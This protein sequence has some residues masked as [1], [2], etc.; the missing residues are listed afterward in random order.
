MKMLYRTSFKT[1]R[2]R[3][4]ETRTTKS[5]EHLL[6]ECAL[7]CCT[8]CVS[9]GR[10]TKGLNASLPRIRRLQFSQ[11]MSRAV[12]LLAVVRSGHFWFLEF[13][14]LSGVCFTIEAERVELS[15]VECVY[16]SVGLELVVVVALK[17]REKE[18]KWFI[19]LSRLSSCQP[20]L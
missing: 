17:T 6:N 9:F 15:W 3:D 2:K 19:Q 1:G 20:P 4:W 7:S 14:L 10:K 13:V 5:W 11:I 8:C 16:F 12:L 18:E